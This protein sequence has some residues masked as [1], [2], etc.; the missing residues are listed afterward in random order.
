MLIALKSYDRLLKGHDSLLFVQETK[1]GRYDVMRRAVSGDGAAH[2]I[3]SI[4]DTWQPDGKPVPWGIDVVLNRIIAHDTWR[5]ENVITEIEDASEKRE[6]SKRR[7][8]RNSVEAFASDFR[9]SFA[10]A[11]DGINTALLSKKEKHHAFG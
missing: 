1:P 11:T 6:E 4:T 3:F 2:F 7:A 9:R 10:R 5:D 8:L